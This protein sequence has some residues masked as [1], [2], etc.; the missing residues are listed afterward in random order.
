MGKTA[1]VQMFCSGNTHF[2]K[3]YH[4]VSAQ[5]LLLLSDLR[6]LQSGRAACSICI[7]SSRD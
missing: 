6:N 7:A 1:L 4:M 2:P 3:E 5:A